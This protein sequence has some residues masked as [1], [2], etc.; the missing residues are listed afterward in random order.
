MGGRCL[1]S[2]PY[3]PLYSTSSPTVFPDFLTC[4]ARQIG[5]RETSSFCWNALQIPCLIPNTC[6]LLTIV[7]RMCVFPMLLGNCS[8]CFFDSLFC[9]HHALGKVV[10]QHFPNVNTWEKHAL[11]H[12]HTA[13]VKTQHSMQNKSKQEYAF[14]CLLR[15]A[16]VCEWSTFWR[17]WVCKRSLDT[18]QVKSSMCACNLRQE[19]DSNSQLKCA[20]WAGQNCGSSER[21]EAEKIFH[22]ATLEVVVGGGGGGSHS[23]T[24]W[25][26][27]L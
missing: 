7:T 2:N 6:Y 16:I 27:Q 26:T 1:D 13:L 21:L 8:S 12:T 22:H 3:T 18:W 14:L 5:E 4:T 9:F 17:Q 24:L 11:T 23:K 19:Q 10:W 20:C 25:I 15:T